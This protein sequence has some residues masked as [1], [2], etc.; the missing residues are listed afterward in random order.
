MWRAKAGFVP[1][2]A[3]RPVH[4]EEVPAGPASDES[5]KGS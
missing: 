3:R 2:T 5:G 4:P 1:S